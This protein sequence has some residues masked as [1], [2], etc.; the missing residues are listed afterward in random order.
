MEL[1][2]IS[3][4]VY[5]DYEESFEE[6]YKDSSIKLLDKKILIN[7][8][9]IEIIYEKEKKAIIIK[10]PENS[11]FIE[12]NNENEFLY[13]TPYGKSSIKTFGEKIIYENSPF[14]LIFEYK[15]VFG[16]TKEYKNIIEILEL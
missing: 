15:I 16:N 12:L 4:Q 2:I 5:E 6:I 9:G 14:K 3:K 8:N 13:E 1:K 11:I 10:R 7:Y